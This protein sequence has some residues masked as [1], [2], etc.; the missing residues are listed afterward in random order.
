MLDD[1]REDP[2]AKGTEVSWI[3][4]KGNLSF[5]W[6]LLLQPPLSALPHS[7]LPELNQ[8]LTDPGQRYEIMSVLYINM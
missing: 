7:L 8:I 4:Q 5:P 1:D 3:A 6:N 2:L